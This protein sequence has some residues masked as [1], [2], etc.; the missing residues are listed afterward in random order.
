M[1]SF[2]YSKLA[3]SNLKKNAK[4][5]IPYL[6]TCIITT[7]MFYIIYSLS[8]NEGLHQIV[9]GK[10][11]ASLLLFGTIIIAIFSTIFLFY[12]NS[13]L[14][15]RRKKEFGLFNIL[16]MEKRHISRLVMNESLI[17]LILSLMIGLFVGISLDKVMFLFI[18]K[19]LSTDVPLGF[20]ISFSSIKVTCLLFIGI[21][22]FICL[23]SIRQ[24]HIS[25][26]IELLNSSTH[27]EKEPKSKWILTLLGII[28]L[29][30][31][32]YI[33]I[34][35]TNPLS[36][37]G[38]F[39]L[40]VLCVIIGTYLLFIAGSVTVLKLLKRNKHFYYQ[41]N[42]FISISGMIYRMKQ[43]AVG[44]ANICILATMV[45]VT[46]SSTIS[47][48]VGIDDL[49]ETRY[50]QEIS[51]TYK[52]NDSKKIKQLYDDTYD[53]LNKENISIKDP[54]NYT[55]LT[56]SVLYENNQYITDREQWNVSSLNNAYNLFFITVDDYNKNFHSSLTLEP[57]EVFIYSNR[58]DFIDTKIHLFN[59]EYKVKKILDSFV[60]NGNLMANVASTHYIVVDSMET[61]KEIAAKQEEVFGTLAS[62]ITHYMSFDTHASDEQNV[63][64]FHSLD[65][66]LDSYERLTI[67]SRTNSYQSFI[68]LYGG[69]MFL[70][71]FLS[72][73]FIMIAI[74]IIYYKQITEGYE[75]K[76]RY[77]IMQKV[78][79]DHKTVKKSINSQ[80]L[81][82]FFLPLVA[83][84]IHTAFAFPM[85]SRLL[86]VLMLNNT[87]LLIA[88]TVGCIFVFGVIYVLVYLLTSKLYYSI[89]KRN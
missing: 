31:G 85:I 86:K 47:L 17:T 81:M 22:I 72:V 52:T 62:N 7:S 63:S 84:A 66:R 24:I 71:L 69:L 46:L 87:K 37:F 8:I 65:T 5:Y 39:F 45:L 6:L 21:Q 41:T 78:G 82:V 38:L 79:M 75:D 53:L 54:M 55:Y 28:F 26:P 33:S 25:N 68:A 59:K 89:V 27:G 42:H 51:L 64:L 61:M 44:L 43:N 15:K 50:P 73:L 13:F 77:E 19:L 88:C 14:V 80:V 29:G 18:G 83:A 20:S 4:T 35:T 10:E 76:D 49:V 11:I 58:T 9:G 3:L 48:W 57:N 30:T 34:T 12:T 74:L 70:G 23:N 1:N 56:F 32:Y 2:F 67:E 40:A 36:A 16:G 60:E